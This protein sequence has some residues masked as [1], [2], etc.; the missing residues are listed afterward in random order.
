MKVTETFKNT[1]TRRV[2]VNALFSLKKRSNKF[3]SRGLF[4]TFF[5]KT[6]RT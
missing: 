1:A 4:L 3:V 5:R 2:Q 6:T